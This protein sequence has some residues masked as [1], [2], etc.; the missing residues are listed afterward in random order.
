MGVF[1]KPGKLLY[2]FEKSEKPVHIPM[3]YFGIC[4]KQRKQKVNDD[5]NH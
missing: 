4:P 1:K 5:V 2:Q 3:T